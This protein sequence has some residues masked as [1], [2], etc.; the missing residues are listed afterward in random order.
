M[1]TTVLFDYT[2]EL[3]LLPPWQAPRNSSI[4]LIIQRHVN[5]AHWPLWCM[6]ANVWARIMWGA[7]APRVT[8]LDS[9]QPNQSSSDSPNTIKLSIKLRIT[10]VSSYN[11]SFYLFFFCIRV[12]FIC[13]TDLNWSFVPIMVYFFMWLTRGK[14]TH[15]HYG[16]YIACKHLWCYMELCDLWLRWLSWNVVETDHSFIRKHKELIIHFAAVAKSRNKINV[17]NCQ[18]RVG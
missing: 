18:H 15:V 1:S 9:Y 4:K 17:L 14:N 3:L 6:S 8:V 2:S 16:K 11:I 7:A 13:Y 12:P 10:H 5:R